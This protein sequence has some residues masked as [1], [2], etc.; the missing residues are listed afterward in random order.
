MAGDR[1][2]YAFEGSEPDVHDDAHVSRAATLVG[3]VSIAADA[4]VWPGV[5]LRGDVGPV[6][7]GEQAH[8]GDNASVHVSEL[9]ARAMVGHGAVVNDATVGEGTLVGFNATVDE[10][11]VGRNCVVASGSVVEPG[12][13][14]DDEQFVYGVPAT[15]RPLAETTVD[16]ER[17]FEQ[18][19]SGRYADLADRHEELFE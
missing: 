18:Y 16:T 5:V 7:V 3:D 15:T 17:V 13:E 14:I 8:V 1:R 2:S 9:G 12:M 19:H 4:S 10:S 11:T 6:T